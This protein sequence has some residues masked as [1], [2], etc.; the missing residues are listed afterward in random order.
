MLIRDYEPGDRAALRECVVQLQDA[1]REIEPRT[2][3]GDSIADTYIAN[4]KNICSANKGK[5][6]VAE[7]DGRVVGYSAVQ[8]WS[9]SDEVHEE[10]YEYG[11][12]SDL[13]V[14][15][16]F[17]RRGLGRALLE[18]AEA[19]TKR[20]HIDLVRIGVLAGNETVRRMYRSY[21]FREHKVVLEKK[22]VAAFDCTSR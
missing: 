7:L 13:V 17:R 22:T 21:G 8:L 11:Y 14:L 16:A 3:D 15:D 1:E 12:V 20:Q 2:A 6:F 9:N 4:L 5:I 18:A 10:L 19:Y